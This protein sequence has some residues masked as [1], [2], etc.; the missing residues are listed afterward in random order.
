MAHRID[1]IAY[2]RRIG[3]MGAPRADLACLREIVACHATTIAF[4]NL[5]PLL[6]LPVELELAA[7][8]E[9]MVRHGRGGYCFE[10]NRLL[11]EMLLELGFDVTAL[12]ARV[13]W[14]QPPD[15]ITA[16]SHMLLRVDIDGKPWLVDVGFGGLTL[17]GALEL[18]ADIE[19]P[20]PHEV[21][22]L[23]EA[24][25]DWR[26][27]ARLRG[28]WKTLYRFD[29]Q[30]QQPIDYQA[31][32]YYLSTHPSSHFVR[33]LVAA[34]ADRGRRLALLNAEFSVHGVDGETQRRLLRGADEIIEVLEREFLLT[35]PANLEL[36]ARLAALPESHRSQR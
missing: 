2:L 27:Q 24:G 32:N 22:R 3:F 15:A 6:G 36:A 1:L 33:N 4:E 19:Q 12:A 5:N 8:E 31:A 34:R 26:M 29:L 13:L 14:N 9:K 17:T 21:F 25:G 28:E 11:A 7:I 16:R 18:S 35:L 30:R 10:H 20:T 23:V